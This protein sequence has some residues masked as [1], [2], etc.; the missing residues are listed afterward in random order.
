M[1]LTLSVVTQEREVIGRDDIQRLIVPTTEG[2]ITLL[3]SHAALMAS[4]DIGEMVAIAPGEELALAIHGGFIQ[5]AADEVTVLADAAERVDE[6]DEER[7]D[8]A[9]RRAEERLAGLDTATEAVDLLRAQ[10]S[11]QRALLRQRVRRHGARSGAPS[12]SR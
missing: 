10:L 8:A 5:I 6:I 11:L 9:R 7:A 4:L 3:P 12:A 2:Q 1:P